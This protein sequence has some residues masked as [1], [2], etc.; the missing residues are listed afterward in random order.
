MKRIVLYAFLGLLLIGCGNT[1][2]SKENRV[3]EVT[4]KKGESVKT[5]AEETS[6]PAISEVEK[7]DKSYYGRWQIKSVTGDGYIF[8]VAYDENDYIGREISIYADSFSVDDNN[9]KI[10]IDKP[11]YKEKKVTN[12]DLYSERKIKKK[13]L[14]FKKKDKVI[15]VKVCDGDTELRSFGSSFYIKDND[16]LIFIGPFFFPESKF[17]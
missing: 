4:V 2:V 5:A 15:K 1:D 12:K 8:S 13:N 10:E 11:V 9:K 14:G 6:E 17:E 3:D 7:I 16:H